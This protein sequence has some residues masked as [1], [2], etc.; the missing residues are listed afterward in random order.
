MPL[1]FPTFLIFITASF[2]TTPTP[3]IFYVTLHTTVEKNDGEIVLLINRTLAPLGVDH[4]WELLSVNYYEQNS[5]FRVLSG[6]VV[7]FGIASKP[8]ISNYWESRPIV[9]DP[10][11]CSNVAGTIAYAT[12][13]NDTRTTQLFINYG[14]NTHLDV[15]RIL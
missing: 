8:S 7:Q 13:G 14:S 5:F 12:A 4:F 3:S 15:V 11:L 10:V 9:D 6:F 1:F 2:A